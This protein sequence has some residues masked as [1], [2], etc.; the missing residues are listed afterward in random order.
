MK[1][2]KS[3]LGKLWTIHN[4]NLELVIVCLNLQSSWGDR[5]VPPLPASRLIYV[6]IDL[7]SIYDMVTH[8]GNNSFDVFILLFYLG[9]KKQGLEHLGLAFH[10][11]K[12]DTHFSSSQD[13]VPNLLWL[14]ALGI[15]FQ[16]Y[17]QNSLSS[18]IA[19]VFWLPDFSSPIYGQN[20]DC[21]VLSMHSE[22]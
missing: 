18:V 15:D 10:V 5:H 3:Y 9:I 22:K 14:A 11:H 8:V 13:M 19:E 2:E 16:F 1:T 6:W 7:S 12:W 21:I 17:S 20:T 4:L